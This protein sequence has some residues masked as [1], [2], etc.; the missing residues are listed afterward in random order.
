[1]DDKRKPNPQAE[2]KLDEIAKEAAA[3][4]WASMNLKQLRQLQEAAESGNFKQEFLSLMAKSAQDAQEPTAK[5]GA[6]EPTITTGRSPK[7]DPNSP[8]FDLKAYEAAI[9]A[10]GGFDAVW[11]RLKSSFADAMKPAADAIRAKA[12]ADTGAEERAAKAAEA[13]ITN[14]TAF[15][16]TDTYK[17]VKESIKAVAA[18]LGEHRADFTAMALAAAGEEMQAL[19]PF[20]QLELD[21]AKKA[22]P[23]FADCTLID[24]LGRG[25]DENGEL[26][27]SKFKRLIEG[28][29]QRRAEYE[30][31]E[32]TIS[33]IQNIRPTAHTMPNNALM[34]ILQQKPAI[35]AGAFD[36]VVSN[37]RGKS[38]EITAY[39]MIDFD[40]GET[41]VKVI[42][43][44]LSEYE[45][46]VSDAVI[47]LWAEAVK[48]ELQPVFTPDMI[49]RAMPGGS[50]KASPQQ[51]GAISKTIEKF[52][53]L[54]ITV[55]ATDEMRKRRII[56]GNAT[57]KLDNFY[58]SATH[59]EYREKNS[60]K[61]V[62]AYRIDA[63]PI[64]FTYCKMTKQLLTVSAEYISIKKVKRGKASNELVTMNADRQAMAGYMLRRIAVMRRDKKNKIQTHSNI[65]S[66]NT[67]FS[68]TNTKTDNRK[69]TMNNRNFCFDVLD[70]WV[71]AGFI[72]SHTRQ[73]QGRSITGVIIE[74]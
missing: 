21:E 72:K 44:H 40:P 56:S 62:N 74:V 41:G 68:E 1:M 5:Q 8:E 46:Q 27:E 65:I 67:L 71:T 43:S 34:N 38:K 49:F 50:D 45:R 60:G 31:A 52:R 64:I 14:I 4:L 53:R 24:I 7:T 58:L 57:F 12:A 28:A 61:T 19:A 23:E 2:T 30:A 10:A 17:A 20:L 42:G 59:A 73:V 47:S 29:R 26:T 54:H 13:A 16:Q 15:L 11:K 70:Y 25:L 18:F 48:K 66:F 51:K 55:D 33:I 69:Q 39:T 3:Q 35:N 9:E 37:A 6:Q 22:D 36:M 32:G 63:E